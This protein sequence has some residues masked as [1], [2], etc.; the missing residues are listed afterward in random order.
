MSGEACFGEALAHPMI[1]AACWH[2]L[3]RQIMSAAA[4]VM[5]RS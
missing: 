4:S 1:Q 2:L 3:P 5:M